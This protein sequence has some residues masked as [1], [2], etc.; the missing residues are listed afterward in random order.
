MGGIELYY[1]RLSAVIGGSKLLHF[2]GALG[3]LGGSV[4]MFCQ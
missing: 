3:V 4:F 2:L 1:L